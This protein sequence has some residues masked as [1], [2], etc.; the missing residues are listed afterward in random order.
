MTDRIIASSKSE[1]AITE[2]TT[3]TGFIMN[4]FPECEFLTGRLRLICRGESGLRQKKTDRYRAEWGLA[5]LPH[6]TP[7]RSPQQKPAKKVPETEPEL[8]EQGKERTTTGIKDLSGDAPWRTCCHRG[9]KVRD[10]Q[11]CGCG[12]M[13]KGVYECALGGQC[14]KQLP[15]TRQREAYKEAGIKLCDECEQAKSPDG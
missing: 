12:A 7:P 3:S 6:T 8:A 1:P 4:E 13:D 9:T 11:N 2:P 15:T 5:P 14:V 10:M